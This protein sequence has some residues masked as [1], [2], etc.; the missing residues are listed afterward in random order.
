[1]S[2]DAPRRAG[3]VALLGRPNVGKSTL[4][5]RLLAQKISITS[6]KPQ[7]TRHT[8]L[9]IKTLPGVQLVYVDTPGLHSNARRAMNRYMNRAAGNVMGY[10]DIVV[11]IVDALAWTDEDEAVVR[12]LRDFEGQIIVAVNKVDR[13]ADKT[14]LLPFMERVGQYQRDAEI[15]PVSALRHDNLDT[16]ERLIA[17]RLPE[18]EFLFSED[19]VTT[20]SERFIAAELIRE[21]LTRYLRD[22]LPYA[23]TV[24]IEH[25]REQ[26]RL[27]RIGAVIW[28]ERQG[29][30][31]IIIG[32][33]GGTLKEIGRQARL[34]M[35]KIFRRKVFLESWVKVREGWADDE[36]ALLN[37]GYREQ[38]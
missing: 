28:V 31:A 16:L 10:V 3:Y 2:A 33:K 14:L 1:M 22:E 13:I 27:V 12:R 30:K 29:Q 21:K 25:F 7:T 9:G 17:E 32:E 20:A 26:G 38:S 18:S 5:N 8:I 24:E 4:L 15:I 36:R 11:L 19:Q 23:L 6:P 34:D 37:L 35:E